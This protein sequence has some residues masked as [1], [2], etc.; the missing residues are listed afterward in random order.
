MSTFSL[1]YLF[2]F[3]F[4]VQGYLHFFNRVFWGAKK[5]DLNEVQWVRF[6]L[7][8]IMLLVISKKPLLNPGSLRF[9]IFS[10]HFIGLRQ[11]SLW[12]SSLMCV[13]VWGKSLDYHYFKECPF[14]LFA[15]FVQKTV[16]ARH[17]RLMPVILAIWEAEIGRITIWG[18]L[19]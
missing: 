13:H 17:W 4:A 7:L 15:P 19:G 5:F 12:F 6:V 8:Q 10:V 2:F 9:S 18:H 3:F 11:L 16:L 14:F 1:T